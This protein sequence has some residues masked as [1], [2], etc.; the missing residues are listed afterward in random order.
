MYTQRNCKASRAIARTAMLAALTVLCVLA[1][2]PASSQTAGPMDEKA[3][4]ILKGMSGYLA[5]AQTVSFRVRTFF[6]EVRESG[7]KI[8]VGRESIVHLKRPNA[9]YVE[10]TGDN[11]AARTAWFDGSK[12]TV[13]DRHVN[14]VRTLSFEG[15]T[16]ALLDELSDKYK[17]YLPVADLLFANIDKALRETIISSEY[18]GIRTVGGVKCHH[19]SFESTGADWQI[20]IEANATPLPRRF[21][22]TYVNEKA[23]PQFLAQ[24]D[25]WA[26]DEEMDAS[27]FKAGVPDGAKE[28]EFGK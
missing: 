27:L 23:E 5:K 7:I 13:W 24:L 6:D 2:S 9:L 8:K 15:S 17:I 25:R 1:A 11:G 3:T 16:D 28:V 20:W 26:I 10:S 14:E 12:L 4:Q 19:L 22:V 18:L 21:A